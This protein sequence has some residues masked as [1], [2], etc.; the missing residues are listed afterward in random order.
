M[1]AAKDHFPITITNDGRD[2]TAKALLIRELCMLKV[3]EEITEKPDWW[4][5]IRNRDIARSWGKEILALDWSKHM[6][7]ADFTSSMAVQVRCM[8]LEF[9]F[10]NSSTLI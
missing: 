4:S 1:P 3:V 10:N 8:T 5:N 9:F 2:W 7:Y 6:K